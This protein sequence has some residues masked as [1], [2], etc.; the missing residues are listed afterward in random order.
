MRSAALRASYL[1]A[2]LALGL[3]ALHF[4]AERL[5]AWTRGLS[6]LAGG[7]ALAGLVLAARVLGRRG[8]TRLEHWR[9]Q[10]AL[11]LNG[12]LAVSFLLYP[13]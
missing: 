5:P 3:L 11:A 4:N 10:L 6:W 1:C 13:T 12:F 8:W 9:A 2:A 7:I